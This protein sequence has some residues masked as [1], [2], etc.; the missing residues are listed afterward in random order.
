M[1][2]AV[3]EPVR[4]PVPVVAPRPVRGRNE[5]LTSRIIRRGKRLRRHRRNFDRA[6]A[7]GPPC[8]NSSTGL[9]RSSPRIEIIGECYQLRRTCPVNAVRRCD[10]RRTSHLRVACTLRPTQ[11]RARPTSQRVSFRQRHESRQSFTLRPSV[12][13]P[14]QEQKSIERGSLGRRVRRTARSRPDRRQARGRQKSRID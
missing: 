13:H 14:L 11:H 9:L 3:P 8:R 5:R 7:P 12:L 2:A 1:F 10:A 6:G 4:C